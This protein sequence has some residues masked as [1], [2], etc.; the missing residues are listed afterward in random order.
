MK[1]YD[2]VSIILTLLKRW[3]LFLLCLCLSL[4]LGSLWVKQQIAQ[5]RSDQSALAK[6]A[7]DLAK[8]S[9]KNRER[10]QLERL[11]QE[12]VKTG[13]IQYSRYKNVYVSDSMI[14]DI[15]QTFLRDDVISDFRRYADTPFST[16]YAV[17][18]EGA[19][20]TPTIAKALESHPI[21][22]E[23][24]QVLA[25]IAPTFKNKDERLYTQLVLEK[26]FFRAIK[27][28]VP[29]LEDASKRPVNKHYIYLD[30]NRLSQANYNITS[31]E[32]IKNHQ[33]LNSNK[34][35][36]FMVVCSIMISVFVVFGVENWSN[37]RRR[38]RHA[39]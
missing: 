27:E 32:I 33:S 39:S 36:V 37:L 34:I 23:S 31:T 30:K 13:F 26:G 10:E 2:D 3:K 16:I 38:M 7:Q 12:G 22:Q 9:K 5:I 6:D 21:T 28:P 1:V 20:P 25:R 15:F 8:E 11:A 19:D 4:A 17:F 24:K 35:W 14:H 29:Y 18:Y